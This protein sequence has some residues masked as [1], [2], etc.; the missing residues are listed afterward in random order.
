MYTRKDIERTFPNVIEYL[1]ENKAVL[2]YAPAKNLF[3][4]YTKEKRKSVKTFDE[5]VEHEQDLKPKQGI[6]K[7]VKYIFSDKI[8]I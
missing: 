4:I 6:L 8:D 2:N 1:N 5:M 7:R 3:I